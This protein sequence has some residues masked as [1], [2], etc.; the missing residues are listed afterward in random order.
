MVTGEFGL[1]D[2]TFRNNWLSELTRNSHQVSPFV[3]PNPFNPGEKS[4]RGE[5]MC[6]GA[7]AH[8]HYWDQSAPDIAE[9]L[10]DLI[11]P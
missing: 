7:G 5:E 6:I 11:K 3:Q 4:G 9:K 1:P 2:A 8:T 10:D